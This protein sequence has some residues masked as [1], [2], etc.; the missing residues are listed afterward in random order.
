[1]LTRVNKFILV[2]LVLGAI[3]VSSAQA[4]D[5]Q[6]KSIINQNANATLAFNQCQ[7]RIS[8]VIL[9][10]QFVKLDTKFF[11]RIHAL[12]KTGIIRPGKVRCWDVVRN[13]HYFMPVSVLRAYIYKRATKEQVFRAQSAFVENSFVLWKEC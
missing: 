12:M 6:L 3:F 13:F 2:S 9:M 7:T 11:D 10:T 1:M 5:N 8:C 4:Q